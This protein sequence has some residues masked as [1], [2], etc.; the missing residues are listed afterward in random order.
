[1]GNRMKKMKK[2]LSLLLTFVMILTIWAPV[3][4]TAASNGSNSST[5]TELEVG[6]SKK[7]H[8]SGFSWSTT[9]ESSDETVVEVS[10]NG[11]VTGISP[12][13]ATVTASSRSFGWIFTRKEKVQEFDIIVVEGEEAGTIEI[14]IGENV[15]LDAPSRGTTTWTSSNK[16]VATVSDSGTVTG[17]S[18]GET[19]VTA[20]TR[21]GGFHFWFISWGGT[22]T[23]TEY[24][25][26]VVDNGE[27]PDPDPEPT[28]DPDPEPGITEYTVTFES[29][30][31]SE[32]EAQI[33]AEGEKVTEPEDPTREGYIFSGWYTDKEFT[34]AYDFDTPVTVDIVLYAKWEEDTG[35]Y[36]TVSFVLILDDEFVTNIES[37][38]DVRVLKGE[39][40]DRPANPESKYAEFDNWY[41]GLDG[42]TI[43]NFDSPVTE[44]ISLFA[45]WNLD[46]TD[47]D[48]DGIYDTLEAD[49]GTDSEK[50]DTDGDGLDDYTEVMIDT[51][52]TLVDTDGDSVSDYDE[53][54]DEDGLTNGFELESGTDPA[55][56][57]T[58]LD[59][60]TD[61]EEINEHHTDPLKEDTDGDG[62]SDS[63]E[64]INGFDPLVADESFEITASSEE[65]TEYN[66]T[67]ASVD[68]NVG[69]DQ[70]NTLSIEKVN[71]VENPL[72][73]NTI[74]GYM[75]SGYDFH[76]D[77]SFESATIHFDYNTDYFGEPDDE[78]QPR[79][80]YLN[81]EYGY[82]EELENQTVS[83]GR[84]SA[85]VTH[86][87][88]YVLLNKVEFDK[89]W[90]NDIKA[91][92]TENQTA[93]NLSIAFVIDVSGSMSGSNITTVKTVMGNFIESMGEKDR[94]AIIK[95]SS[96]ASVVQ[97]LTND[98]AVL[99]SAIDSLSAS[100]GTTIRN[101]VSLGIDQLVQDTAENSYDTLVLL[102]DGQDSGFNNY[103]EQYAHTCTEDSIIAYSI[104][105]GSSVSSEHLTNFAEATGGKYYHATVAEELEDYFI[106]IK[107]ETIDYTTD[108][109]NDGLSDYYTQLIFEGKIPMADHLKGVDFS[110]SADYDEDGLN[111]GEEIEVINQNNRI[112]LVMHSDPTLKHSDKDGIDDYTEVQN[113]SNPLKY[114]IEKSPVD[115]LINDNYYYSPGV[116]D[117]YQEGGFGKFITDANAALHIVWNRDEIYR[118]IMT[119]YFSN[120]AKES[121]LDDISFDAS[122]S[123]IANTLSNLLGI[124]KEKGADYYSLCDNV[125]ELIDLVNGTVNKADLYLIYEKLEILIEEVITVLPDESVTINTYSISRYKLVSVNL[126][127]LAE[128]VN[129]ICDGLTIAV[130]IMDIADTCES[131]S[132]VSA[133]NEA[134]EQNLDILQNVID[135]SSDENAVAAARDVRSKLENSYI[136]E[137]KAYTADAVENFVPFIAEKFMMSNPY[138]AAIVVVRNAVTLITG[139]S[140]DLKQH[141]SMFSYTELIR[142]SKR[143]LEANTEVNADYYETIVSG[144]ESA[145]TVNRLLTHT[146]QLRIL[147]ERMFS[148]W[149]EDDGIIGWFTDNSETE[150]KIDQ[151]VQNIIKRANELNLNL[152]ESL[153]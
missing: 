123:T 20:K 91:P 77:G 37:F 72:V 97:N 92:G 149:Q 44:N 95:F 125:L 61:Y 114:S 18:A 88:T 57:D 8:K 106:E 142:A 141:F 7:L 140:I 17:V 128:G 112:Y 35:D 56:N 36:C 58:D 111:N 71:Y 41:T 87:S 64:I 86:F 136:E 54:Y 129:K 101:G 107:G 152:H 33:I 144:N 120:Y 153:L 90:E 25:I 30:G 121:Y 116:S 134:F 85:T 113:G 22:T 145:E 51:D 12:G 34:N 117:D 84:V 15:D 146:A 69:G 89:V 5:A 60:L 110:G 73:R 14:G 82:Y 137:L 28:P 143:L 48:G 65:L 135:Y 26:V 40:V 109:N 83:D 79:I 68:L 94:A 139:I 2:Y 16:D 46:E 9:W 19:T 108:S 124:L 27:T 62:A 100:G 130:G 122:R 126:S 39:K 42:E 115:Y 6:E 147:D 118:D 13:E 74:P 151:I 38:H 132:A 55:N 81:E 29:N 102:T 105:I 45:K 98:K 43:Y 131:F 10:S 103:W 53:D 24:H 148:D 63:W 50:V 99:T 133:N 52:P 1:M 21:T 80:Y 70:V 78:F 104:G 67:S 96:S 49:L 59:G 93:Q 47:T 75:G 31:G 119:D 3:T 127:K 66:L 32:V 150:E 4:A 138:T 23:T 11:T 76:L